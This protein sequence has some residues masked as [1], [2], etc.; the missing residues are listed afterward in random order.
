MLHELMVAIHFLGWLIPDIEKMYIQLKTFW[1]V[2]NKLE[3]L[4]RIVATQ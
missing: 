1:Q 3:N 4:L 2:S